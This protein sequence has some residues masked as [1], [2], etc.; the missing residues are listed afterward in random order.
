MSKNRVLWLFLASIVMISTGFGKARAQAPNDLKIAPP[1]IPSAVFDVTKYGAV[2]NAKTMDT[3]ALQKTIDACSSAGGGVVDVPA[4]R[5]LTGPFHLASAMNLHLEKGATILISDNTADFRITGNRFEDCVTANDCHDLAITGEGTIDGQGAMWWAN[6]SQPGKPHRPFL[7]VINRCQRLLIQGIT[8]RN[9]P[10]FHLV[11]QGCQDVKID[12][13]HILA[14][15]YAKN[16]DGLDPAA[17]NMLITH[18]T[19][20]VGDDCIALKPSHTIVAGQPSC[21]NILIENC[22]FLHG[23]GM[24]VGGQTPAGLTNMTVRNCTFDGTDAG[25]RLKAPRGQGGLVENLVYDHLT[26]KDVKVPILITSYYENN[27]PGVTPTDPAQDPAQPV[28]ATTPIW[29]HIKISNV[30]AVGARTDGEIYGLPEMPVSDMTLTNVNI[31]GRH[32]MEII[33]AKDIRFS[34]SQVTAEVGAPVVLEDASVQGIDRS[35]K[36]TAKNPDAPA[37][38]F[39]VQQY[40]A[41]PDGKTLDTDAI[42]KAIAT[43]SAAGGG[44]VEF[45]AGTYLT[46]PIKLASNLDLHVDYGALVLFSRNHEDYPLILTHYEGLPAIR[47]Q[48]P[49][50]GE[51][52]QNISITGNGVFD[53]QGET[54]RPA[55][56]SKLPDEAWSELKAQGG[57]VD[58][59]G[60]W[61][62]SKGAFDGMTAVPRLQANAQSQ[63]SDY[64]PYRDFLRPTLVEI[65]ECK[66]VKLDGPTFRNSP[67]WNLHILLSDNVTVRNVTSFNPWWAQ[68]GDG[69]DLDSCRHVLVENSTF[70]VG[71]D[72]I[73]LKSGKDEEGR[74]LG[75][76]TEDVRIIHDT[77]YRGH[78]GVVIGSEMSGG[79]RNVDA[80]NCYFD[81]TD[82]GLRFKSTRGRGGVV[83]DI[84]AN[85]IDMKDIAGP[86][87]SFDMF[88][89]VRNPQPEPVS[90]RT[91]RFQSFTIKNINCEGAQSAMLIRGLPEMPVE[92]ITLQNVKIAAKTG[93]DLVDAKDITLDNV[94]VAAASGPWLTQKDVSNLKTEQETGQVAAL[95]Q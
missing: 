59:S 21:K 12:G 62:P 28:S 18:C 75:R 50:F 95:Q 23:H 44:R 19:F 41:V 20:D 27:S 78:G 66:N 43:C 58:D 15:E 3:A 53:G 37:R 25:I 73:C 90:E 69:M 72:G 46:G 36:P 47:C 56:E 32:G 34:K 57:Y 61:W 29:Q 31:S 13:V 63:A 4:G 8:L 65:S 33:H 88:Y 51:N 86:A 22:T 40:G 76:P 67:A 85:N 79:V 80:E 9:S 70:N 16:T 17:W 5:Y 82:I 89:M 64:Q 14:P 77:V 74:K 11:P 92:G 30:S 42:A 94:Q 71:D 55:K 7:V 84:T 35:G 45:P 49:L 1:V 38:V 60:T 52:L 68:N 2:G 93:V 24:S 83:E 39:N 10:M 6:Y 91:P 81:G 48:S 26:M 87:I 54:W